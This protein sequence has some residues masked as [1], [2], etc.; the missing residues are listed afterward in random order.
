[1]PSITFPS[2]THPRGGCHYHL[3][4][5]IVHLTCYHKI[6]AQLQL[7][8]EV[9]ED[10]STEIQIESKDYAYHRNCVSLQ[11]QTTDTRTYALRDRNVVPLNFS[12]KIFL[13][14]EQH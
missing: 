13:N 1:M 11:T 4:A 6:I 10:A 2:F 5:Y 7:A 9:M 12:L 14:V 3:H 8:G